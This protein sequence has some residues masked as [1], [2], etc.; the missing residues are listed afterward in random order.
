MYRQL[1]GLALA[2]GIA[3]AGSSCIIFADDD[4]TLTIHNESSYVL[5]EVRLA[6]VDDPSWGPNLLP[7]V[8]YPGEHLVIV[9]IDCGDYDVL[10]VDEFGVECVLADITLC[11][12][13]EDWVIDDVTLDFCAF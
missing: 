11:F 13:D 3:S 7:D 6:E 10:V 2:V 5:T 9:D 12:E 4:A 1:A 8:L